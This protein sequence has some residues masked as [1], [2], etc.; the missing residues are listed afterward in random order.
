MTREEFAKQWAEYTYPKEEVKATIALS[1]FL[2]GWDKC[3]QTL[4]KS[5]DGED[6]PEY[7]REVVVFAQDFPNDAGIMKVAIAHRPDPKGWDGKNIATGEVEHYTPQTYGK[8]CWNIPDVI[9]W[10]DVDLPKTEE[11]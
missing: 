3:K 2:C 9:I 4:W 11:F 1:A 7:E 10:L 8:G 6:L 5:A